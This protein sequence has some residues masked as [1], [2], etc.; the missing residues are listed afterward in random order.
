MGEMEKRARTKRELL[1]ELLDSLVQAAAAEESA[2]SLADSPPEPRQ[3][4]LKVLMKVMMRK[5]R[6]VADCMFMANTPHRSFAPLDFRLDFR[7]GS[8]TVFLPFLL[9]TRIC[10]SEL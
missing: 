10:L 4:E 2:D 6:G 9:E 7:S 1:K 8:F 5:E 3:K